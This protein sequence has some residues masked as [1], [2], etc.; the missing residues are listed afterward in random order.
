RIDDADY[1]I[2]LNQKRMSLA[3]TVAELGLTQPPPPGFDVASV[4]RVRAARAQAANAAAKRDRIAQLVR[5]DPSAFSAQDF[6]DIKTAAD[7][8]TANADVAA[9]EA[10]TLVATV[11]TRQAD[12]AK[13]QR[14]LDETV[15]RAPTPARAHGA[16]KGFGIA[17]RSVAVGDLLAVGAT[18]FTLVED[19]PLKFAARVPDRFAASIAPGQSVE[20]TV[21]SRGAPVRGAVRRVSP[22]VDA[23]SRMLSVQVEVPND[24]HAVKPGLFT[25]GRIAVGEKPDALFVPS[26]ALVTFAGVKK[27]FTVKDGKAV[28]HVV[29]TGE[30]REGWIEVTA[31]LEGDA[32]VVVKGAG[33]L[34]RGTP[35]ATPAPQARNKAG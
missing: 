22:V 21:E 2:A 6:E 30:R 14:D 27:V 4:P 18:A 33:R 12:V 35:V 29:E 10:R 31:G 3:E 8:A 5:N 13:A 23:E 1:Q 7:V 11:A 26:G 15:V 25:R 9:L 20:V 16:K 34:T 17:G 32:D 28:E 24:Q 19:D